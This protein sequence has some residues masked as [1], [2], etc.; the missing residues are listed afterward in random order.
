MHIKKNDIVKILSG[1]DKGKKGKVLKVIIDSNRVVVEGVHLLKRH[2]K[3]SQQNQQG[4]IIEKEGT[5]HASNVMLVINGKES[6]TGIK[7][8]D[9]G[10][11][12][13]Y[14]KKTGEMVAEGK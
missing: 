2:T 1:K 3:P 6:R 10:K 9:D 12:V 11:K 13:R 8:L 4:G 7:I 5:I 14:S